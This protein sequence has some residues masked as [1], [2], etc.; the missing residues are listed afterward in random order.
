MPSNSIKQRLCKQQQKAKAY[1]GFKLCTSNSLQK[2]RSTFH[3]EYSFDCIFHVEMKDSINSGQNKFGRDC[4]KMYF[5][6]VE[7]GE[8]VE[9]INRYS[10]HFIFHTFF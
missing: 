10:P 6:C 3:L 2:C 1:E 5:I 4:F 7:L 9:F 8:G